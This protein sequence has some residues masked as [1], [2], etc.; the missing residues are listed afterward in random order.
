MYYLTYRPN[1][2]EELDNSHVRDT[3]ANLLQSKKLPHALLFV[4]PKG[5][6]KT[7][8]ARIVAK[9]INCLNNAFSG[10]GTLYDPCNTCSNCT[11][12]T[13]GSSPDVVEQD[14]ASNRGIDEI[15]RLIRESSF[16]PMTG[17]YRVYIID[18]AHM[19]T[20]DAFNA[21]LKTLEEPPKSV[22]FILA[23]TNEEKLPTTIISR[24]LRIPFG[25]AKKEDIVHMIER[26]ALHEK[27]TLTDEIK[28]LIAMYSEHSFRDATKLLEELVVQKKLDSKEAQIY[29]GI[30]SKD[31]LLHIIADKELKDAIDWIDEF[32]ASGGNVKHVIED[33]LQKLRV[34]L[35]KKATK[36]EDGIDINLSL[37]EITQLVKLLHEAYNLMKISPIEVLP[38]EIAVVEFYNRKHV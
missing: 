32:V 11:T 34:Y 9:A 24:C 18:E 19:I 38:L 37:R 14:A 12:I 3:I 6:G 20:P 5:T 10:H 33:M 1:T 2:I 22:I 7:S 26:I 36:Q 25:A 16:M 23:T 30:R 8:T 21:L 35:V 28:D 13:T 4:G 29:L 17:T 27:L 15:R 31:S